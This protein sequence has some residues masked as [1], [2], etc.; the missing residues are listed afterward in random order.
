[1]NRRLS[2]LGH[3]TRTSILGD[4]QPFWYKHRT[5]TNQNHQDM[6]L[7]AESDDEMLD[8]PLFQRNEQKRSNTN[9]TIDTNLSLDIANRF[10]STFLNHR[11]SSF[12]ENQP[13]SILLRHILVGLVNAAVLVPTLVGFCSIIFKDPFFTSDEMQ[14]E[15]FSK[16]LKLVFLSSAIHQFMFLLCSSL[17]FAVGQVQDAG[18]IFL[19]SMASKI[20]Q[21]IQESHTNATTEDIVITVLFS[22]SLCTAMLG[23]LL[24]LVGKFKLAQLVQ[25]LPLPVVGGYLAFIGL[26]CGLSGLRLMSGNHDIDSLFSL[27]LIFEKKSF[28]LCLPGFFAATILFKL[29][30][31]KNKALLPIALFSFPIIFYLVVFLSTMSLDDFRNA[32]W[33]GKSTNIP[34]LTE[35]FLLFNFY[36]YNLYL[37]CAFPT[38]LPDFMSMFFIVAFGSCLDVAAIQFELGRPLDYN[39]EMKSVGLSNLVSGISSGY[40]GSYIFSQTIFAL[41]NEVDTRYA[42]ICVLVAEILIVLLPIDLLGILPKFFF[43]CVLLFVA[44][45]LLVDWMFISFFKLELSEYLIVVITFFT[46]NFTDLQ[47]G[48]VLGFI[49]TALNFVLKHSKMTTTERLHVPKTN[50]IRGVEVHKIL[51]RQRNRVVVLKLSGFQFFGT[52]Q[53]VLSAVK[54]CIN[55]SP[56]EPEEGYVKSEKDLSVNRKLTQTKRLSVITGNDHFDLDILETKFLILDFTEVTTIDATAAR[57]CFLTLL[58]ILC[59]V[60]VEL[61]CCGLSPS[62]KTIL[63][64]H[65]VIACGTN[66]VDEE[67]NG[68]SCFENI[69]SAVEYC[70]ENLSEGIIEELA[71]EQVSVKLAKRSLKNSL[72]EIKIR[73]IWNYWDLKVIQ[74]KKVLCP[75]KEKA[76]I[77]LVRGKVRSTSTEQLKYSV[78]SLLGLKTFLNLDDDSKYIILSKEATCLFLTRNSLTQLKTENSNLAT[79]LMTCLLKKLVTR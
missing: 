74:G 40:T 77:L 63:Q 6:E 66:A 41:K 17:P 65:H 53:R 58:Y 11:I 59:E 50:I 4:E 23:A 20:V 18:L 78:G 14:D 52:T 49:I 60:Q 26:F 42:S 25:Y 69:L 70:E 34:N 30:H 33:I 43:G 57:S 35:V 36:R 8:T 46:I 1:M 10:D 72:P 71:Y 62:C 3:S 51:E 29:S 24:Y 39:H 28:I 37:G 44:L 48:M 56:Q 19:S 54:Q 45:D 67:E 21:N 64:K 75:Q 15:Y 55:L 12:A 9:F 27:N 38:I 31:R 2:N 32:G 5:R 61:L 68:A 47:V 73:E 16:F 79:N 76:L 13:F 22:L 7:P